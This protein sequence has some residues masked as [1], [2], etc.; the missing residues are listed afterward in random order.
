MSSPEPVVT[1]SDPPILGEI[2]VTRPSVIG[3]L[4]KNWPAT[5]VTA[6]VI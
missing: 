4:V 3:I 1:E 2:V 6:D 5:F